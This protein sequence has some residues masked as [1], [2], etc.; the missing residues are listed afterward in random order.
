MY[1]THS[2]VMQEQIY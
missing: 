2:V 1:E